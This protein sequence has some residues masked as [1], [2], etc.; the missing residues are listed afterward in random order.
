MGRQI[1]VGAMLGLGRRLYHASIIGMSH[2]EQIEAIGLG[3]IHDLYQFVQERLAFRSQVGTSRRKQ[4][5]AVEAGHA[6]LGIIDE[7]RKTSRELFEPTNGVGR[8]R[9]RV[10]RLADEQILVLRMQGLT[11]LLQIGQTLMRDIQF[12]HQVLILGRSLGESLL[13]LTQLTIHL[14]RSSLR[15]LV[16]LHGHGIAAAHEQT[17]R[18]TSCRQGEMRTR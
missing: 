10:R 17:S 3:S 9:S 16:L 14:H 15:L 13:R 5:V 1:P 4:Q 11:L 8:E 6:G 18:K 7:L 12:T 2:D